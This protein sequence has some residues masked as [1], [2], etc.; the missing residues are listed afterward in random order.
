MVKQSAERQFERQDS[1]AFGESQ[2]AFD[3]LDLLNDGRNLTNLVAANNTADQHLGRVELVGRNRDGTSTADYGPTGPAL[4]PADPEVL[5]LGEKA[6]ARIDRDNNGFLSKEELAAAKND[7]SFSA[8][9]ANRIADI[10]ANADMIQGLHNDEFWI[11]NDGVTRGDLREYD[12]R[13][14]SE[15]VAQRRAQKWADESFYKFDWNNDGKLH[16]GEVDIGLRG[17]I[18]QQDRRMLTYLKNN[19]MNVKDAHNDGEWVTTDISRNDVRTL[20][21]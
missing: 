2:P 10:H 4:R 13:V 1:H 11:E 16:V 3:A 6:F 8:H 9:A 14:N 12:R 19:F 18:T 7:R 21:K 15:I 17:S 5:P 20:Q